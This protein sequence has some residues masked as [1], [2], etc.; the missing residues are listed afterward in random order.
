MAELRRARA[1]AGPVPA[2]MVSA[3]GVGPAIGLRA[4]KHVVLVRRVARAFNRLTLFAQ[5]GCP[6]DVVSQARLLRRVAVQIRQPLRDA[7]ALRVIPGTCADT[8]AGIES[9]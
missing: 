7:R 3:I 9:R 4:G 1:A 5:G 8:V 2:R 6:V